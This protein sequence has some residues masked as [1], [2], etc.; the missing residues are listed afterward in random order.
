MPITKDDC[1]PQLVQIQRTTSVILSSF[2]YDGTDLISFNKAEDDT[3]VTELS[4]RPSSETSFLDEELGREKRTSKQQL[5]FRGMS[6]ETS[7]NSFKSIYVMV[8]G[9]SFSVPREAYVK[10]GKL[11]WKHDRN[12]VAHL[13]TSPAIFEVLLGYI[14]FETL[15]AYDTLSKAEYDEFE[16]MAQNLRLFELIEHFDRS[17]NKLLRS[18]RGRRRSLF[19]KRQSSINSRGGTPIVLNSESINIV[20]NKLMAANSS[21]TRFVASLRR[22]GIGK[23]RDRRSKVAHDQLCS[24]NDYV[25]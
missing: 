17:S 2:S 13:N 24:L 14:V 8:S 22:T 6:Q 18:T 5:P 15:P 12:G 3:C 10:L 4:S 19:S 23:R 1:H 11:K 20:S 7:T 21:C 25:S 9:T 16:P